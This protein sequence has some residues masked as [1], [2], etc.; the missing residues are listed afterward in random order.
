M[1]GLFTENGPFRVESRDLQV[2]ALTTC[3]GFFDTVQCDGIHVVTH[4]DGFLGGMLSDLQA[5]FYLMTAHVEG[6]Q[7]KILGLTLQQ[8]STLTN[9]S[10]PGF[11]H[12]AQP[13]VH[14][15]Q[16]QK[17]SSQRRRKQ[18]CSHFLK[19]ILSMLVAL[20]TFLGNHL[21]VG[22]TQ[23]SFAKPWARWGCVLC[24]RLLLRPPPFQLP[25]VKPTKQ[26]SNCGTMQLMP[27]LS[28][29]R[30]LIGASAATAYCGVV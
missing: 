12:Q 20:S 9:L 23:P 13:T 5:F 11:H 6:L 17:K 29:A 2:S 30:G 3:D 27:N 8:S 15:L 14:P 25:V 19:G 21:R 24:F 10:A 28:T 26:K 22:C 16:R 18:H 1:F 7:L 4:Q